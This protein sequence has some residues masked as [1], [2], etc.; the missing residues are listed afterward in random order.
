MK[1]RLTSL[2]LL[3]TIPLFTLLY[4][5]P[6]AFSDA[7]KKSVIINFVGDVHGERAIQVKSLP[8]LRKY[9][10]S[11]DLNIFNL[12]TAVTDFDQKEVKEYNFKTN[13]AFL[14]ALKRAGLN[15]A[16]IGNNH[17]YDYGAEGFKDT[18][19]NLDKAGI[20]YVGGGGDN[21]AAYR[22]KIFTI[23][24]LKIGILGLAKVNGGPQSIA[25]SQRAGTTNGYDS[26][27][28][29]AAITQLKADSDV[30]IVVTHWGEEGSF[31]PRDFEISSA[32]KWFSLGADIIL[33]SHTH[34]L[35]PVIL[36]ANKLVAYSMGNFIFYSSK[37]EN[38]ETGILKIEISPKKK[39]SY[40]MEPFTINNLSKI[41][42]LSD[43][44]LRENNGTV[45]NNKDA[46]LCK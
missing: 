42:E 27:S 31:C 17:S 23:N 34:T 39:I 25:T 18:L 43:A 24:G 36:K 12:E 33:G 7:P 20:S 30:V 6:Q 41:P 29:E 38:R 15:V 3:G 10:A 44:A 35:Q 45:T 40:R 26:K 14:Q 32:K 5:P 9:F 46:I 28:S 11:G 2:I 4:S 13:L 21:S 8:T 37:L 1:S 19:R 16:N 22:G